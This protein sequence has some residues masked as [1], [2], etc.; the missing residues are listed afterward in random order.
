V[1]TGVPD[2][3]ESIVLRVEVDERTAGAAEG[4]K[5]GC[6][7]VRMSGYG[8]AALFEECADCVVRAVFFVC[9]FGIRP[10]LYFF[11]VSV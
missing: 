11:F 3:R 4:F 8:K 2:I 9:C 7:A 1:P 6:Q 10:D 5:G